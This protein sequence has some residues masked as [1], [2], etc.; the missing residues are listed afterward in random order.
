MFAR[1]LAV[2]AAAGCTAAAAAQ[3][4]V[5]YQYQGRVI[6]IDDPAGVYA[7]TGIVV[8]D[9]ATGTFEIDLEA[10]VQQDAVN[11]FGDLFGDQF[12]YE[13]GSFAALALTAD[14]GPLNIDTA[15]V[16]G[17]VLD[18][19]F[20]INER[21]DVFSIAGGATLPTDLPGYDGVL[22][23]GL[24]GIFEGDDSVF[25]TTG[26]DGVADLQL[27]ELDSAEITIEFRTRFEGL[28]PDIADLLG[29]L[30][31]N[32]I[33][34]ELLSLTGNGSRIALG[35]PADTNENGEIDF[36]DFN[37]W[38]S[39]YNAGDYRADQNLDGAVTPGDFNAW[40]LA[41]QSGC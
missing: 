15:D 31:Q 28:D 11:V 30:E 13:I 6:A 21:R 16:R 40:L 26:T 12:N 29:L 22:P 35:C 39:L 3:S 41:F 36:G 14:L 23:G 33:R 1:T 24:R 10:T 38:V 17:Q 5:A 32:T 2:L 34:I 37:A 20:Q 25:D 4:T 9:I 19:V 27:E 18:G 7:D 8:G